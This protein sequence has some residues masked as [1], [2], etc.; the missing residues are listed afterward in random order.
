MKGLLP[1]TSDTQLV[2]GNKQGV[3]GSIL[4]KCNPDR[5]ELILHYIHLSVGVL[6]VF[7]GCGIVAKS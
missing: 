5:R 1:S 3:Y 2:D 6:E 7:N 4:T